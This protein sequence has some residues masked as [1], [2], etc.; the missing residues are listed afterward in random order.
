MKPTHVLVLSGNTY[1]HK[2]EI[3]AQGFKYDVEHK[4]WLMPVYGIGKAAQMRRWAKGLSGVTVTEE[5]AWRYNV[6]FRK[7]D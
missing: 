4:V 5:Y 1:N 3:Q 6:I 7:V 2:S